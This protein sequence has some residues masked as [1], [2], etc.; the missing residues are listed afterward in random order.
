MELSRGPAKKQKWMMKHTKKWDY[1]YF[2]YATEMP[3]D[4]FLA[5]VSG[6]EK[7]RWYPDLQ[8]QLKKA[9]ECGGVQV[10]YFVYSWPQCGLYKCYTRF[11]AARDVD[12][13]KAVGWG[14]K[15][16]V[17]ASKKAST[18]YSLEEAKAWI[19]GSRDEEGYHWGWPNP[20]PI[21]F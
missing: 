20:M 6:E 14:W 15:V 1:K 21:C 13:K 18:F 17:G 7:D 4:A 16:E 3:A 10:W 9:E 12:W 11:I 8:K 5:S 19:Q 2:D